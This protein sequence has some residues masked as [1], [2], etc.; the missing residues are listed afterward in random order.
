MLDFIFF[1][2]GTGGAVG[3]ARLVCGR[4]VVPADRLLGSGGSGGTVTA[5]TGSRQQGQ[6][7][8]GVLGRFQISFMYACG[9]ELEP[10]SVTKRGDAGE[11][12]VS[13]MLDGLSCTS[14]KMGPRVGGRS[15]MGGTTASSATGCG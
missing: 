6:E 9:E 3:L 14:A 11:R 12:C 4:P 8:L 5:S 1:S 2:P 13:H 15:H 10:S 7:E